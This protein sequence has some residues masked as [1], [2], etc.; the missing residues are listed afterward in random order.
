M[1]V[2]ASPFAMRCFTRVLAAR[3]VIL[4]VF[5]VVGG[6]GIYGATRIPDDNAIGSLSVANDPDAKATSA[7]EKV[8]PEGV[9]ALLMLETPD[10]LLP[11]ALQGADR[12]EHRL[13]T[14]PG[15]DPQSLLTIYR[16]AHPGTSLT[17]GDA[18]RVRMFAT[19]TQLFTR[20]GLVGPHFLGVALELHV[21]SPADR[22]RMLA[23]IDA[24]SAPL[25]RS[26]G[27]AFDRIRRVGSPWLDAWLERET[28]VATRRSMPL[29]GL[30][31]VALVFLLY[32]SWRT[33]L[34]IVIT[35]GLVVAIALGLAAL[36]GWKHTI[37]SSLVPL[38]VLV[39]ATATL[40]YIHSR[41]IDR[42]GAEDLT[43][44]HATVL[45][46]KFLPCTASI[47]ATAVGF[48]A[49]AVSSIRPVREMGLW[50]AAGLVV[51]WVAS[52][53]LFPAL[54]QLLRTPTQTEVAA[55]GRWYPEF[56]DKWLP[57]TR[58]LRWPLVG[59]AVAGMVAGVIALVG[60][61]GHIRPLSL[62]TDTLT[63]IDPRVTAAQDT[64]YFE[65]QNGLG[66]YQLW[67]KVP[68]GGA[69][70]PKFLHAVDQLVRHLE[71]DPRITAVDGPTSLLRWARY[72]QSGQDQLPTQPQAWD[73]LAAQLEQILL[74][75]PG[76][77]GFVDVN[78]LGD[79]RLSIR[80][81]DR[82]F[83]DIRG[84]RAYIEHTWA[85]VQ[86]Q[87]PALATVTARVVGESVLSDQITVQL[88]PTLMESF[89]LTASVIFCAFL[90]VFRSPMARLMAMIP[91]LFAILAAFLV[92]RGAGISLNIA[93]ILIGST[94]LGATENDQVHFFYHYQEGR[95]E[96][97][98]LAA[99]RHAFLV[100]GKPI[101][102]AT[103]INAAGFLALAFSPLPPMRQFGTVSS[104]AFVLAL[105]ADFTALPA[106][107][108]ICTRSP[109]TL[110][111]SP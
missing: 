49:L 17:P 70:D 31:L 2:S 107:L 96:G 73:Q 109:K 16:G 40:V 80:G 37:V 22:D 100:A 32:R 71:S 66:V 99:L 42:A 35:L 3:R 87:Q 111:S 84:M 39:T 58:N 86:K 74:T 62:Q 72:V 69:L 76:T 68:D 75:T 7:F 77:R 14:L 43:T 82:A 90:L 18:D 8:F 64:R 47:F 97:S 63:Y 95:A 59:T 34:A 53:T 83:G 101:L 91:S 41:F 60:I 54:Q 30:F 36:T 50:T 45:A 20:A 9:H 110:R 88:V 79:V 51:A 85:T 15:V 56:V 6:L 55:A 27:G 65:A 13:A 26:K 19:G 102:F 57:L 11:A 21:R 108:W 52:F 38:T 23:A 5:L 81:R 104:A 29:F 98:T 28:Q 61:P 25:L 106:A 48:A 94:V 24:A 78:T 89:L 93:T 105:L 92:M 44:H 4:L 12:L 103:L 1:S 67:L 33:L 10:P 46:N